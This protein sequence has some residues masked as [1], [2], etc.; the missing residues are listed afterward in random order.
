VNCPSLSLPLASSTVESSHTERRAP[1][2]RAAA[3]AC[4]CA[5]LLWE[6]RGHPLDGV[7]AATGIC[8]ACRFL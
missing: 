2:A 4:Q 5:E 1:A 3:P 8:A 7:P 6:H